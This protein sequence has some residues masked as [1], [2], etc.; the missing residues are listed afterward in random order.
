MHSDGEPGGRIVEDQAHRFAAELLMP[1]DQIRPLLPVTMGGG[2]WRTF[3]RL[4]EQWSVS[5]QA[6]L[7]RARWLGCLSDVS[8]RNAMTT[9]SARGWRRHEPGLVTAMEQPSLLARAVELLGQEG[10]EESVLVEQ[11]RVPPYL[12][13]IVTSRIPHDHP[14][15]SGEAAV[16]LQSSGGRVMSLLQHPR[17]AS[18]DRE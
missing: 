13:R 10:I 15:A 6:L 17:M 3:A 9:I 11:C 7:Y 5:I 2:A 1:A 14:P 16:E 12:F 18:T 4:K 8:Y